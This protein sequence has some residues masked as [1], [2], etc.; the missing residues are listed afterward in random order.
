MGQQANRT[1][2]RRKLG[3]ALKGLRETAQVTSGEA[4]VAIHGDTSKISR[5]ETGRHRVTRLELETLLDLYEVEDGRTREWLVALA[6]EERKRSW[7]RKFGEPLPPAL[8]ETLTLESDAAEIRAFQTQVVPG[9]LQTRSYAT[10]VMTGSDPLLPEAELEFYLDLRMGRQEIFQRENPP[11]YLCIMLEGA[12]RQQ[13][14]GPRTMADQLRHLIEMSRAPKVTVQVIPFTEPVFTATGGSFALFSHSAPLNLD[15]VSI[16]HLDGALYLEEEDETVA[17][18][19][20]A[21]Q[22]LLATALSAQ[23]S[24]DLMAAIIR[25]LERQ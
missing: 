2:R 18:Y 16:Q 22:H 20:R 7:W 25:G 1:A 4:A 21:W 3:A 17:K 8:K 12:V 15:V 6:L 11:D 5:I 9:L 24:L 13:V 19:R 14:G 10:A 23:Q